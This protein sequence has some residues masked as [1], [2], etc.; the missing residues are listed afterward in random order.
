MRSSCA[1]LAA[2]RCALRLRALDPDNQLADRTAE[3]VH[4]EDVFCRPELHPDRVS[5]HSPSMRSRKREIGRAA[6]GIRDAIIHAGE[7][8]ALVPG[9]DVDVYALDD[10]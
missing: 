2:T 1:A 8:P 5:T 4:L 6:F 3:R 7:R 9:V 10:V